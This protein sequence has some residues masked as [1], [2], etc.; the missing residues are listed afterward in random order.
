MPTT[1]K[2]Y[3]DPFNLH[4]VGDLDVAC[5]GVGHTLKTQCIFPRSSS[6]MIWTVSGIRPKNNKRFNCH[7]KFGG[8]VWNRSFNGYPYIVRVNF[9]EV[10]RKTLAKNEIWHWMWEQDRLNDFGITPGSGGV[11]NTQLITGVHVEIEGNTI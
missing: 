11:D 7:L 4:Y 3:K 1:A 5:Q 8:T 2:F 9:V 6:D 10:M